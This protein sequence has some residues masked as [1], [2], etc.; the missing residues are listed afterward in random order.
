MP[1][2]FLFLVCGCPL[3]PNACS[4]VS[5]ANEVA[6]FGRGVVVRHGCVDAFAADGWE[7]RCD[8]ERYEY[9]VVVVLG[10]DGGSSGLGGDLN[11][12]VE[13]RSSWEEAALRLW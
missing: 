6:Y 13:C 8:V 3:K 1:G 7:H 2:V 10:V 9:C 11:G 4:G 5:R 12:R